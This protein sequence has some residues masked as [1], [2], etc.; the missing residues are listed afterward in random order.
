MTTTNATNNVSHLSIATFEMTDDVTITAGNP[1]LLTSGKV[2]QPTSTA[3]VTTAIG[4]A[5]S[6]KTFTSKSTTGQQEYMGVITEGQLLFTGL[7]EASGTYT[8]A[9]AVGDYVSLYYDGTNFY[10]VKDSTAPIGK[11]IDGNVDSGSSDETADLIIDCNFAVESINPNEVF[12]SDYT[13]NTLAVN[14]TLAVTGI[15]TLTGSLVLNNKLALTDSQSGGASNGS[16]IKKQLVAGEAYTGT[17]AGTM[18]KMYGESTAT[19]PSGEFTGFYV[20]LK[21]L[22]TDPGNNTSIISA[23]VH[24]SNTTVVHAGL[25]LYG[26]M[27]N[28]LKMSGSTLTSALDIS[29]ATAVTNI[30]SVPAAGTA[31]VTANALVP[32]TAPD[33]T[34]VGADAS[35]TVDVAGTPYYIA[36]YDTLHA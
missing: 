33:A 13:F 23:H 8:T 22:H 24:A 15:T 12:I 6:T 11:V 36:L 14:S 27:T 3:I 30:F 1:L 7:V 34:T 21:G 5:S 29:E 19:V 31:P 32:A 18:V 20:S 28:G 25:W 10:V 16:V 35:L 9:I 26:D 4:V 2:L 17:T